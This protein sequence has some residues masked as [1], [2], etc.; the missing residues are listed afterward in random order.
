MKF[1]STIASFTLV[2]FFGSTVVNADVKPNLRS[3]TVD[4]DAEASGRNLRPAGSC[5]P[6][7][8]SCPTTYQV[9]VF[10]CNGCYYSGYCE[11]YN[12][13]FQPHLEC[14]IICGG[15][16]KPPCPGH[17]TGVVSSLTTPMPTATPTAA[18]TALPTA[19]PTIGPTSSPTQAPKSRSP[20][21]SPTGCL[22]DPCESEC[23]DKYEGEYAKCYDGTSYTCYES[24]IEEANYEALIEDCCFLEIQ[25]E[26]EEC[27]FLCTALCEL[28][29]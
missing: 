6:V 9:R 8:G 7:M 26:E 11:A 5:L 12:A 25:S 27:K 15:P 4:D 16:G 13:G 2:I 23:T 24:Y 21:S 18:P 28:D 19:V 14:K 1:L 17:V 29:W 10:D 22:I 20:T 3:V